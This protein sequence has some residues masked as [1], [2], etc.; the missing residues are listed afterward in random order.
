[1]GGCHNISWLM[2]ACH[3][4]KDILGRA[5]LWLSAMIRDYWVELRSICGCGNVG[6]AGVAFPVAA[7]T[8]VAIDAV[9][10]RSG[11]VRKLFENG[12]RNQISRPCH[13]C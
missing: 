3:T 10:V 9:T 8:D 6:V 2:F 13:A 11:E 7:K 5:N 1:M 12:Q 4:C